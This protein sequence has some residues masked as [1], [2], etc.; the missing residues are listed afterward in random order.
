[1]IFAVKECLKVDYCADYLLNNMK[2]QCFDRL[3]YLFLDQTVD[4]LVKLNIVLVIDHDIFNCRTL[5][6]LFF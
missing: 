2:K 6:V 5:V 3:I 1:M 4:L